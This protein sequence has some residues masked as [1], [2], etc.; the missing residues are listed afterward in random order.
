MRGR[1]SAAIV[2]V[3]LATATLLSLHRL[4]ALPLQ[5]AGYRPVGIWMLYG[6]AEPAHGV[7]AA[8]WVVAWLATLAMLV[9]ALT[10]VSTAVSFVTVV[11]LVSL[12]VSGRPTWSHAFNPVLLAHLAFLGARGGD[13]FSVDALIRGRMVGAYRWSLWLVQFAVALVFASAVYMKLKAGGFGLAWVTSD[14]LRNQFLLRYDAS[15]LT[16]PPIVEWLIERPWAYHGAAA[17]SMM[18]QTVPILVCFTRR[19]IVRALGGACFVVETLG[20]GVVMH[21]WN[22]EW[23][24]LAA[25]FIDWDAL[26]RVPATPPQRTHVTMKVFAIVFVVYDVICSF[27]VDQRLN[28]YPFTAFPMFAQVRATPPYDVHL[29]YTITTG[30]FEVLADRP[31]PHDWLDYRYRT[32]IAHRDLRPVLADALADIRRVLPTARVDQVRLWFVILEAPAY[33]APARLEERRIGVL[34]ALDSDGG[35]MLTPLAAVSRK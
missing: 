21:L 2:R 26:L 16:R 32:L 6:H 19:P 33:P 20:I 5:G 4:A 35:F 7:I 1:T 12:S 23:L 9:G 15:G 18:A 24:P 27:F 28:T 8:L 34:A 25:V 10:R 14:N 11:A 13:V 17:F 31:I 22:L 30:R 3:A 29:P